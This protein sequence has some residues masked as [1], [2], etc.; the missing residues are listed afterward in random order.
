MNQETP[1]TR[2]ANR[3]AVRTTTRLPI[4][5]PVI[6]DITRGG[7]SAKPTRLS[8][9]KFTSYSTLNITLVKRTLK[10]PARAPTSKVNRYRSLGLPMST[11]AASVAPIVSQATSHEISPQVA[12]QAT[13]VTDSE[14]HSSGD[15]MG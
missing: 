8:D 12:A 11:V 13:T 9:W 7:S 2:P 10:I 5:K 6:S 4:R 3:P 15:M 1:T 14:T